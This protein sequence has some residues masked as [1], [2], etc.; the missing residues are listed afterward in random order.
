VTFY[1]PLHLSMNTYKYTLSDSPISAPSGFICN[2]ST[3]N[4]TNC[5]GTIGAFSSYQKRLLF[6]D[7]K[8]SAVSPTIVMEF[9]CDELMGKME[10]SSKYTFGSMRIDTNKIINWTTPVSL[11]QDSQRYE[12][13]E[14]LKKFDVSGNSPQLIENNFVMG[15]IYKTGYTTFEGMNYEFSTKKDQNVGDF[16]EAFSF[17]R[18]EMNNSSQLVFKNEHDFNYETNMYDGF[19]T[20]PAFIDDL[21]TTLIGDMMNPSD[22]YPQFALAIGGVVPTLTDPTTQFSGSNIKFNGTTEMKLDAFDPS[23]TLFSTNFGTTFF[24]SP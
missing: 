6:Y 24:T 7:Y 12:V 11:Y 14:S 4:E 13:L 18:Y 9:R 20:P 21:P 16:L 1:D 3:R 22:S 5:G 15:R 17:Q 8:N 2:P 19:T 23:G 10:E